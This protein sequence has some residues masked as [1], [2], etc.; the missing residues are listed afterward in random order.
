MIQLKKGRDGPSTLACVRADGTRTWGKLHP[1]F[2]PHDLTH[3]AVE[4]VLGFHDAFFGLVAAGWDLDDFAQPGAAARLP[5][6]ALWAENIVGILDRERLL[7]E[8]LSP[9]A[10]NEDLAAAL[11]GQKVPVCSPLAPSDLTRIRDLR[12]DLL[13]RWS[14]VS[15]GGTLEISFP[16]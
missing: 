4:S 11:S 6:Q 2:P 16:I 1:F 10:F 8:P 7:P 12:D 13:V 15:A 9:Q 5:A 14:S 3:C